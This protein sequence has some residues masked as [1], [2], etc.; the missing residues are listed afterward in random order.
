MKCGELQRRVCG[1]QAHPDVRPGFA[2]LGS[3]AQI[4]GAEKGFHRGG[5][6]T[7]ELLDCA[8]DD[9]VVALRGILVEPDEDLDNGGWQ[10][11]VGHAL[12]Q[13]VCGDGGHG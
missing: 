10:A 7:G 8:C 11:G 5:S 13:I 1:A 9:L 12:A 6:L 4:D 2:E 3:A